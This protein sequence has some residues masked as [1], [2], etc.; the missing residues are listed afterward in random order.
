MTRPSK[1]P[2]S[3]DGSLAEVRQVLERVVQDRAAA[4]CNI[5][6]AAEDFR[7][8]RKQ[9]I[10]DLV[11]LPRLCSRRRCRRKRRCACDRVPCI[12]IHRTTVAERLAVLLG[13]STG[14]LFA[15]A[16]D[17]LRW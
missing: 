1:S 3:A 13:Y 17:D 12:A 4:E 14:E 15:D 6:A 5:G 10:A 11:G 9:T 8:W 2:Q 7:L 16:N